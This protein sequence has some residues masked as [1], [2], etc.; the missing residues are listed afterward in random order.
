MNIFRGTT[1][2]ISYQKGTFAKVATAHWYITSQEVNVNLITF[3]FIVNL[4]SVYD[5][6]ILEIPY[7]LNSSVLCV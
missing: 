7:L 4:A 6:F 2:Q 3:I 1:Y 5:V